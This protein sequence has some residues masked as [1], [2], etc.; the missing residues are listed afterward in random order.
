MKIRVISHDL[1]LTNIGNITIFAALL[2]VGVDY[3]VV[4]P[5]IATSFFLVASR[6]FSN[7]SFSLTNFSLVH[8]LSKDFSLR[9]Y[10]HA[11]IIDD[12]KFF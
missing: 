4:E 6:S 3:F 2:S 5:I 11:K 9:S 1:A 12:F 8:T 7:I 10:F